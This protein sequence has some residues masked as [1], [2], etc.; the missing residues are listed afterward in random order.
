L[1]YVFAFSISLTAQDQEKIKTFRALL[2]TQLA[3]S[4]RTQT[5]TSL[6]EELSYTDSRGALDTALLAKASAEKMNSP[7]LIGDALNTLGGIYTDMGKYPLAIECHL[8]QIELCKKTNNND[9]LA[10]A[11]GNTGRIYSALKMPDTMLY[12]NGLAQQICIIELAKMEKLKKPLDSITTRRYNLYQYRLAISY[13]NMAIDLQDLQQY[14]SA[15]HYV[16]KAIAYTLPN[17]K[18]SVLAVNYKTLSRIYLMHFKQYDQAL[19]YGLKAAKI[20]EEVN[21]QYHLTGIYLLL[22]E[23]KIRQKQNSE[24]LLFLK[25][26]LA[27][28]QEVGITDHVGLTYKLLSE[29]YENSGKADSALFFHKAYFKI[30]DTILRENQQAQFDL[31]RSRMDVEKKQEELKIGEQQNKLLNEKAAQQKT[32]IWLIAAICLVGVVFVFLLLKRNKEKQRAN[33]LLNTQNNE[34][35]QQKNIVEIKNKEIRDSIVYAQRIQQAIL[36]KEEDIR[37][38]FPE[39]YLFYRPKDI[40][41][42]DF[43][44]FETTDTHIFYSAADC[45]GHGV[46][47][48]LVSVVC[49]NALTRCIKEFGLID[50]GQILD[51]TRDLVLNTFRKSGQEIKDGM[52]ISLIALPLNYRNQAS[53]DLLWSGANNPLWYIQNETLHE[54]TAN[55]QSIGYAEIPVPFTT[56]TLTLKKGDRLFLATDGYAD[57]FGGPKGK[58]F[59]YKQ[60]QELF[61][62]NKSASST[63]QE[64]AIAETFDQWKGNLDQV[65]DVLVIGVVL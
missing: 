37:M 17:K 63:E 19:A 20:A 50:T 47:G 23:V 28:A 16:N 4:V 58:K 39:S 57:Q 65:D 55:K 9:D 30:H 64:K 62:N 38:H 24:A 7:A 25:K 13:T 21:D 8:R 60:L 3:D 10:M 53:I 22:G 52:D 12:Y 48:A 2:K 45:T 54:L 15:F 14:D 35:A 26:S 56:H 51:K 44:F 33:T 18:M 40:V 31:I 43:Y 61:Q 36:A 59:R 29:V 41:A 1:V 42:G 27:L 32:I 46:P 49:A 5:L 34:I 11:Y 6:A